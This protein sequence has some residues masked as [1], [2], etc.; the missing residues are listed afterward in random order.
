[1]KIV[2]DKKLGQ[3]IKYKAYTHTKKKKKKEKKK[4]Q[5]KKV[6]NNLSIFTIYEKIKKK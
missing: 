3:G 4:E 1:M 2:I 6:N 5:L